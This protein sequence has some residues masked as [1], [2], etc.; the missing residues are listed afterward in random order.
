M[1]G[2]HIDKNI[3]MLHLLQLQGLIVAWMDRNLFVF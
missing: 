2:N 1:Y 3:Q